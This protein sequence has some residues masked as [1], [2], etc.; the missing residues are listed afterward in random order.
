MK[1]T[2][3]DCVCCGAEYSGPSA[4][5]FC[6][7]CFSGDCQRCKRRVREA[8]RGPGCPSGGRPP[9]R[10][11]Q[12]GWGCG[13]WLTGQ[14]MRAHFTKCPKRPVASPPMNHL[15]GRNRNCKA[16]RGRPPGRRML[17]GARLTASQMRTHFTKC[18][19]RPAGS[20]HGDRGG[21]S[22]R[23]RGKLPEAQDRL[24]A[25]SLGCVDPPG[26][27]SSPDSRK[28]CG[29]IRTRRAYASQLR[30]ILVPGAIES[31]AV[32]IDI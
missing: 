27:S 16:K 10:R 8:I 26:R 4:Y 20:E 7:R 29:H 6:D 19:K 22:P 23:R 28:L 14:E 13:G 11:M 9:A 12:C 18:R 2:V 1:Y 21:A 32:N 17:C 5:P 3:E 30:A 31:A 25:V 24:A 15:D